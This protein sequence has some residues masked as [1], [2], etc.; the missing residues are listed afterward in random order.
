MYRAVGL[1][2]WSCSSQKEE[3]KG[4]R[5]LG[6][7]FL[8]WSLGSVGSV[9]SPTYGGVEAR[10]NGSMWSL[11]RE[12]EHEKTLREPCLLQPME[13]PRPGLRQ[14]SWEEIKLLGL[15][16]SSPPICVRISYIA[17]LVVCL[18]FSVSHA[19]C[20]SRFLFPVRFEL[21]FED[22]REEYKWKPTNYISINIKIINSANKLLM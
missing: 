18:L 21:C 22:F 13:L 11:L 20:S 7:Q 8:P 14:G 9:F 17:W 16:A 10:G 5:I 12:W 6:R 1:Q 4:S 2:F 19:V 15:L 3:P